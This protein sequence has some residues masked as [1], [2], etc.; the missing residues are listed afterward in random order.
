M[1]T[2]A[3]PTEGQVRVGGYN[4]ITQA[5]EV[6]RI[7]GVALQDVGLDPQMKA[8]ELLSLQGR[9]FGLSRRQVHD[10]SAEL[11]QLVSLTDSLDRPVGK[12]SGG[13]RRRLDLALALVHKPE[14][15]FLDEPTTG[16][17]PASRRTVW[18]EIRR[19]NRDE[20][21]T[22]FLTTQYLEEA[23]ELADHIAIINGGKIV[24]EG[25]PAALKASVGSESINVTFANPDT[26]PQAQIALAT[27]ADRVQV[28]RQTVRLYLSQAAEVVPAVVSRL[29]ACG[30]HPQSLTL[31]QPTLDD[32]FLQV[33]GEQYEK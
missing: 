32:V 26:I 21:M 10:R 33:T 16:L 3:L 30:L 24:I 22:I 8:M 27:M 25:T 12:Y 31:S 11:L 2:L 9:L 15:L 18:N 6:Q 7:A 20:G 1:T 4:V 29:E 19:L 28:D 14:V 5:H 13:M 17:D 23:D